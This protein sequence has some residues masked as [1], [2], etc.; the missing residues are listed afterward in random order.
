MRPWLGSASRGL[1]DQA[2]INAEVD[3]LGGGG[4]ARLRVE[5]DGVA[6]DLPIA[7]GETA[8]RLRLSVGE[9]GRVRLEPGL[10][11]AWSPELER[12][13]REPLPTATGAQFRLERVPGLELGLERLALELG[14]E[15]LTPDWASAVVEAR[16]G[17]D[18]LRGTLDGEAWSIEP[19]VLTVDAP[20]LAR[21]LD[22]DGATTA[23]LGGELAGV[24]SVGIRDA[25]LLGDDGR[26][27]S[28]LAGVLAQ[29]RL[30]FEVNEV[31][32]AV[33]GPLLDPAIAGAGLVTARDLGEVFA[34]QIELVGGGV[35]R[36]FVAVDSERV[37]A[38]AG[39]QIRGG[40]LQTD[41]VGVRAEFA[42]IASVAS[43]WLEPFGVAIEPG[44][45]GRVRLEGVSIDLAGFDRDTI[46]PGALRGELAIDLDEMVVSIE[47]GGPERRRARLAAA[48]LGLKLEDLREGVSGRL[49]GRAEGL[50][51]RLGPGEVSVVFDSG[52]LLD[53]QGRW[54]GGVP[55]VVG[56][57]AI[58]DLPTTL[59]T[60]WLPEAAGGA[61]D[62]AGKRLTI[63][64]DAVANADGTVRVDAMAR[65][66]LLFGEA[67]FE[68]DRGVLRAVDNGAR[69][70]IN[71]AGAVLGPLL[72]LVEPAS[73]EGEA[74]VRVRSA[75]FGSRDGEPVAAELATGFELT[76]LRLT[77][78]SGETLGLDRLAASF[79]ARPGRVPVVELNGSPTHAGSPL[80]VAGRF[81]LPGLPVFGGGASVFDTAPSGRL[82]VTGA[83]V[84][85]AGA[86]ADVRQRDPRELLRDLLGDTVDLVLSAD[87][88]AIELAATGASGT[89]D[90]GASARVGGG[91]MAFGGASVTLVVTPETI[92][93]ARLR[94]MAAGGRAA[95]LG[96]TLAS[97][98]T[99]RASIEGFGIAEGGSARP[100]GS[101]AFSI[102][103]EATI[104]GPPADGR[105]RV[106]RIGLRDFSLSGTLPMGALLGDESALLEAAITGACVGRDAA[107]FAVF[108]GSVSVG[109][110]AG[111]VDGPMA[112]E[113]DAAATDLGAFDDAV[114][115][116][117]FFAGLLGAR[118]RVTVALL[119]E[120]EAGRV[121]DAELDLSIVSPRVAM[122]EPL[123]LA[124]ETDRLQLAAP[125]E[126][127]WEA[128]PL[129]ITRH[130]LS[131]TPGDEAVRAVGPSTV[132]FGLERVILGRS[133]SDRGPLRPGLFDLAASIEADRLVIE[134]PDDDGG[135][136]SMVQT[137]YGG[138]DGSVSV[139]DG[140]TTVRFELSGTGDDNRTLMLEGGLSGFA[141]SGGVPR[142]DTLTL[143]TRLDVQRLPVSIVDAAIGAGHVVVELIGPTADLRVDAHRLSTDDGGFTASIV[144]GRGSASVA[145]GVVEGT[146]RSTEPVLVEV[147]E[148]RPELG[149]RISTAVPV[150][151]EVT[152]TAADG[153]ATLTITGVEI[154]LVRAGETAAQRWR[155]VNADFVID[156]GTA[157][158]STS[159][160]FG[161]IVS[162]VGG[163]R[164]GTVGRRVEPVNG[165]VRN[166]QLRYERFTLPLGEFN[167]LSQ[168]SYNF[169]T[170]TVVV[171]THVPLGALTDE[172]IGVLNTGLGSRF[173][174]MIPGLE[175]ATMIPWKVSGT[176]GKLRVE[177]DLETF[178][179]DLGSLLNPMQLLRGVRD[180]LGIGG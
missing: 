141:D 180:G 108:D 115:A 83:P 117:G 136:G 54:L 29:G 171:T 169:G 41:A 95:V 38:R 154:P 133:G 124:I 80:L 109:L 104:D 75:R 147:A 179:S 68:I 70:V 142:T 71:E 155:G 153:P 58:E 26:W 146:L 140:G 43:A 101:P 51:D 62:A 25:H 61:L 64:A 100:T 123:R 92:E 44:V 105:F 176:P 17:I 159:D 74:V 97:P 98:A 45:A 148:I 36:L 93:Q 8:G 165:T 166:G 56:S 13:T 57:V 149:R 78:R 16:A 96:P 53:A 72:P 131:Q 82:D 87:A 112:V 113:L 55:S 52:G 139:E 21:G 32:S 67:A 84:S 177:P 174:R 79:E 168:G 167:V 106:D 42:E 150:L 20:S 120:A 163:N 40:E 28:D 156:A 162:A 102:T 11:A 19:L 47:S 173:T 128:D 6:A 178:A 132:R 151:G 76:G 77:D 34:T 90:A 107:A 99:V 152:K 161:S 73:R 65:S 127:T 88:G 31:R 39:L 86:L 60:P 22:L 49:T 15:G 3:L 138:F 94:E 110:A 130:A 122:S 119:G 89:L 59:V 114:R 157:R 7:F 23:R 172:A 66:S 4:S 145:A 116:D 103:A 12:L 144:G 91:S 175:R 5:A 121:R 85:L 35:P 126:I 24:L 9:G 30:D 125:T 170:Q 63:E 129:F 137:A 111:G 143:D 69:L 1:G 46:D 33:V 160:L 134:H 14:A 18:E 50:G 81:E 158:F 118:G 10:V 48:S 135:A 27:L 164:D 37:D 2:A